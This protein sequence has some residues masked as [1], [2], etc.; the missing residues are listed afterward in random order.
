MSLKVF[1]NQDYDFTHENEQF[2]KLVEILKEKFNKTDDL[3]LLFAN[4]YFGGVPLDALFVKRNA[5]VVIEFKNYTGNLSVAENGVWSLGD[6]TIVKG[7]AGKN[8]FMQIRANKFSVL[9]ELN[10]WFS[11]PYVNLGQIS[12]VVVFNQPITITRDYISPRS[13]SW[14]HICDMDDIGNKLEDIASQGIN[15][16]ESDLLDI[17]RIFNCNDVYYETPVNE[18]RGQRVE[19]PVVVQPQV[20]NVNTTLSDAVRRILRENH[21]D[22]VAEMEKPAKTATYYTD[23][24]ELGERAHEYINRKFNNNG[25]YK[26]QYDAV[27]LA[28]DGKNV[29]IATSTSSGKTAIFHLAALEILE[30]DPQAK[31]I[32]VYP[33][34][35]L[36][37]QQV[38]SW[39]EDLQNVSC[40]RIDGNVRDINERLRILR[41]CSVVTFTP[42]TIHTF[43][44]G[45]LKDTRCTAT[46]KEFIRKLKLVIIDEVHLYRGML[47]SNC[48]YMFRRLNACAILSGGNVPQYI[49]ASATIKDPIKHSSDISGVDSFEIVDSSMDTSPSC[50]T[51]VFLIRQGDGLASLLTNMATTLPNQRTIT[52]ID[53]RKKVTEVAFDVEA[54]LNLQDHQIYPFKSGFEKNDYDEITKALEERRFKGIVSTS[55]LEVGINIPDLNI[56]ILDGIPNSSTSFYQRLGRVGRGNTTNEAIAII[57]DKSDSLITQR[58]FANPKELYNLPPEEPALYTDNKYLMFIQALHFVGT[59]RE[60]Q[61]VS[62]N[63]DDFEI[64]KSQFS[65]FSEGF[66]ELCNQLMDGQITQE[67]QDQYDLGGDYPEAKYTIRQFGIQYK[68]HIDGQDIDNERGDLSMTNIMREAYPGAIY[69]YWGDPRRVLHVD[70]RRGHEVI[71]ARQI[72]QNIK[73]KVKPIRWIT[74]QRDSSIKNSAKYGGLL[75]DN[76]DIREFTQILGYKEVYRNGGDRNFLYENPDCPYY[77]QKVF[78]NSIRTTGVIITHPSLNKIKKDQRELISM[79][80]YECFLS[81]NAFERSDI[82]YGT[83]ILNTTIGNVPT[84]SPYV[85]IYDKVEGGLNITSCLLEKEILNRGFSVMNELVADGRESIVIGEKRKLYPETKKVISQMYSEICI[86]D[87]MRSDNKIISKDGIANGS[88]AYHLNPETD[89]KTEVT[90]LNVAYSDINHEYQYILRDNQGEEYVELK[91]SLVHPI[92]GV[93]KKASLW[94]EGTNIVITKEELW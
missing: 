78:E 28:S 13:K 90:I 79:I 73:T 1:K 3:N 77:S 66:I 17:P 35:A 26:H 7:G 41:E 30:R 86:N 84:G 80:L 55:S 64:I 59:G 11:R 50:P 92:P 16:T 22:I 10:V 9:N 20:Q 33:M 47:G 87:G 23:E 69:T 71:L 32:A 42:D 75:V 91:G 61:S 83:G 82:E 85:A 19:Q 31:I 38:N 21:Y 39:N 76:L 70:V 4:I 34:K 48:A 81:C 37:N 15:Y 51:K 12:G 27:K 24:I 43:L 93:S 63:N 2:R 25:L 18:A 52:F 40:G 46:I 8:P 60:F 89:E 53:S 74:P 6:G 49:T 58:L 29:C 45:K 88:I 68:A 56:V 94:K 57:M 65:S 72:T 44:L 5:I 62:A 67:F 54:E 14:F 36:G